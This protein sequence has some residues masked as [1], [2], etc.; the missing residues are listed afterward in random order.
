MGKNETISSSLTDVQ[1]GFISNIYIVLYVNQ[2]KIEE[3]FIILNTNDNLTKIM[4][5]QGLFEK[6]YQR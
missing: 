4:N 5:M 1:K 2:I 3:W 6:Y